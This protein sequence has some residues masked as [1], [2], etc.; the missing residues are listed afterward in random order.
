MQRITNRVAQVNN[1]VHKVLSK[2]ET[3]IPVFVISSGFVGVLGV[4]QFADDLPTLPR[5]GPCFIDALAIVVRPGRVDQ[6]ICL[7]TGTAIVEPICLSTRGFP[8]PFETMTSTLGVDSLSRQPSAGF[9]ERR[10]RVRAVATRSSSCANTSCSWV[11]YAST[12]SA[13]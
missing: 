8:V 11:T 3:E 1:L 4:Q 10:R 6:L 13:G 7:A 5:I 2:C 9:C 12:V